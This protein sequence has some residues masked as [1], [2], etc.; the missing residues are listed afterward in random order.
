MAQEV[1][2]T[3]WLIESVLLFVSFSTGLA[4]KGIRLGRPLIMPADT[5]AEIRRRWSR[6][7]SLAA[8]ADR[9]NV[10]A[11]ETAHGGRRWYVSTIQAV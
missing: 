4:E 7:Q 6:G 1:P 3:L 11:R 8:I 2:A 9:L 5:I 10:E